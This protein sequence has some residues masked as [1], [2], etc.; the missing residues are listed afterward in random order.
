MSEYSERLDVAAS[1]T[2]AP[3]AT[4]PWTR[5]RRQSRPRYRLEWRRLSSEGN[6]RAVY[7]LRFE[8]AIDPAALRAH[9][10][11]VGYMAFAEEFRVVAP[12]GSA[13][14]TNLEAIGRWSVDEEPLPAVHAASLWGEEMRVARLRCEMVGAVRAALVL[15]VERSIIRMDHALAI[16]RLTEETSTGFTLH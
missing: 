3:R 12:D 7:D 6:D 2:A 13:V 14:W 10:L 4:M 11:R 1:T 16:A 15:G 8:T 9:A 5:P